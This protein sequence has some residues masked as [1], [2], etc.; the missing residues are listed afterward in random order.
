MDNRLLFL[1]RCGGG[2]GGVQKV[3]LSMPIGHG[4]SLIQDDAGIGKSVPDIDK[5]EGKL[6]R[7][8]RRFG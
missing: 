7:N 1:Y 4:V 3:R 5:D 2:K 6:R 8:P